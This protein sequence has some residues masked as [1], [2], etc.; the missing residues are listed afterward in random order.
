MRYSL[1][2]VLVS[3]LVIGA[4]FAGDEVREIP[5]PTTDGSF[6]GTWYY[7]DPSFEMAIFI[8]P[9]S[10]GLLR[11]RYHVHKKGATEFE[12]D[13]GGVA[14]YIDGAAQVT[15]LISGNLNADGS[16]IEGRYQRTIETKDR[17][18]VASGDFV[19]YRTSG[20]HSLVMNYP[21]YTTKVTDE[22]GR[23]E[24][25]TQTDVLTI[26]RKASEVIIDFKEIPF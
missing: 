14:K 5:K 7:V 16:R 23:T 11:L 1:L 22:K 13:A 8:A 2:G 21:Q 9:D 19:M 18:T 6:F 24:V 10:T 20:G 15:V 25:N 12:T 26:Y 3:V 17:K 4:A